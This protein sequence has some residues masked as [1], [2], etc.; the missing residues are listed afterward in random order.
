[1]QMTF[2]KYRIS[3]TL[4]AAPGRVAIPVSAKSIFIDVG[5]SALVSQANLSKGVFSHNDPAMAMQ[6]KNSKGDTGKT[7]LLLELVRRITGASATLPALLL[8]L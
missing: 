2:T 6:S 1:M 7:R 8:Q 4:V 3:H 5:S